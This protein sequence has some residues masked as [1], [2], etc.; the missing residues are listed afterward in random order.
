V[1]YRIIS[2][3]SPSTMPNT[4]FKSL[5]LSS[6]KAHPSISYFR[7][8]SIYSL[9]PSP[10]NHIPTSSAVHN[11]TK[12]MKQNF[13]YLQ[14]GKC[15]SGTDVKGYVVYRIFVFSNDFIP[16]VDVLIQRFYRYTGQHS[17]WRNDLFIDFPGIKLLFFHLFVS[18]DLLPILIY[19]FVCLVIKSIVILTSTV[20]A[21]L[22]KRA[23]I[24]RTI[25]LN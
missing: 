22:H 4:S 18:L 19:L 9:S 21:I 7:N 25:S 11:K 13:F 16:L 20:L 2:F 1:I 5:S 24:L 15:Q 3:R 12:L 14:R 23:A 8:L 17:L 10:S 6:S